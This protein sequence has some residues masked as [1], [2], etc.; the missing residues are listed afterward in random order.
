MLA[1]YGM[2][3]TIKG[4]DCRSLG[5]LK[6]VLRQWVATNIRFVREWNHNDDLPWWYNERASLSVLAGAVWQKGGLAFEEFMTDKRKKRRSTY[7]GR[8]DLYLKIRQHEFIAEAKQCWSVAAQITDKTTACIEQRLRDACMD[9]RKCPAYGQRKLGVL[10]AGIA[11]S[12]KTGVDQYVEQWV[13]ALKRVDY[14]CCAWVFPQRSR[15]AS[16]N[17]VFYPGLALLIREV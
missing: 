4:V 16:F 10:F 2:P 13:A 5:F 12:E 3:T 11:K 7:S 15:G 6:G 1:S 9:I 14:S 17:S 8:C